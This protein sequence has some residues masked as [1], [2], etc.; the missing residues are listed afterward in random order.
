MNTML[1]CVYFAADAPNHCR[2]YYKCLVFNKRSFLIHNH[3]PLSSHV[4]F[5]CLQ[6]MSRMFTSSFSKISLP[7]HKVSA[8]RLRSQFRYVTHF[9]LLCGLM[10]P[11]WVHRLYN[12]LGL[13]Q[14]VCT[15]IALS[16]LAIDVIDF[17][18]LNFPKQTRFFLYVTE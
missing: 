11:K 4:S 3:C 7:C 2:E 6:P 13:S 8:I 12:I 9:G 17:Q 18:Q 15:Y 1:T 14:N 5:S 10:I 16:L